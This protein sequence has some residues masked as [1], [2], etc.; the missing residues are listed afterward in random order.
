[1]STTLVVW[2]HPGQTSF[3]SSWARASVEGARALGH[4]VLTSDLCAMGFDPVEGPHHYKAGTEAFD[5]LKAAEDAAQTKSLPADVQAEVTKIQASDRIIFHFPVWWFGPP[6]ILKGWFD[7]ALAHGAIHD[8][9]HRFDAGLC[10]GKRAL[11]CVSTG[12]TAAETGPGGKEADLTLLM[13]PLAYALRY[14]GF[15][16]CLPVVVNTVHGYHEGAAKDALEGQITKTLASQRDLIAAMDK[17]P[18]YRFNA[19]TDFDADD[20]LRPGAPSH[21]PF[22]RLPE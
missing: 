11:F 7:R 6:A 10:R 17:L 19:D 13:W 9:D 15:D 12:A 20:R 22:I 1:M 2:A 3:T 16:V 14:C 4:E 8:I 5:P 18:S 21:S